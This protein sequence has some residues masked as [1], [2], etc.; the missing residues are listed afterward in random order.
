VDVIDLLQ[1]R[2]ASDLLPCIAMQQP[3][4]TVMEHP[5]EHCGIIAVCLGGETVGPKNRVIYP[6]Q[7]GDATY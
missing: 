7:N 3:V 2:L 5:N 1:H 4:A 6:S